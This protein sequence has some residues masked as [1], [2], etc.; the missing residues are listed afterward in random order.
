MFSK[1][2]VKAGKKKLFVFCVMC[3]YAFSFFSASLYISTAF[4]ATADL[5]W[6]ITHQEEVGSV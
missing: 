6:E 4:I 3:T 1:I 5:I 2:K